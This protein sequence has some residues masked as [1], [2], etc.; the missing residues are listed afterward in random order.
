MRQEIINTPQD[1]GQGDSLFV[2]FN[3]LNQMTLELYNQDSQFESELQAIQS[4]V[5]T[6][7]DGVS[8]L[9]HK[10]TISQ[11]IGLQ[12]ALNSKVS[13]T[14]FNSQIVAINQTIQQINLTINVI[15][16]ELQTKISDAPS[17]GNVYGRKDGDWVEVEADGITGGGTRNFIPKFTPDET[18]IG[19][20]V[21]ANNANN[22]TIGS[23]TTPYR[24][25]VLGVNA[26]AN[27]P[28]LA[29]RDNGRVGIRT[30]TPTAEL[31]IVNTSGGTAPNILTLRNNAT[32][33]GTG[34]ALAFINSTNQ[35]ATVGSKIESVN[36][37][38][39]GRN[40][41]GFYV[42]GGGG[43]FGGLEERM[44]VDG[45]GTLSARTLSATTAFVQGVTTSFSGFS[46]NYNDNKNFGNF[47]VEN[48]TYAKFDFN[49]E[50]TSDDNFGSIIVTANPEEGFYVGKA[51]SISSN[52]LQLYTDN[53][54]FATTNFNTSESNSF[55]FNSIE[56]IT[57]KPIQA[58]GFR[59]NYVYYDTD[60]VADGN[61]PQGA[62]YWNA[63]RQTLQLK[64]NGT[65]Y[66]YG[67]GLYFYIKNQSGVQINKGDV[68]GFAGT[69]G[70]SGII[71][72]AKY[73]NDGSQ[74]SDRLM[75]VA[76]ENIP[77]GGEGKVVFFGEVRGINTNAF[78]EGTILYASNI[79]AGAL[80]STIPNAGTNKGE[81]AAVISQS[82]TVGTIF[83]RALINK[84]IDELNNVD[85]D[86]PTDGQTLVYDNGI[87]K[88]QTVLANL[89]I[90]G[91]NAASIP[92]NVNINGGGA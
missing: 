85:I 47:G 38:A 78:T 51:D 84:N 79:T 54:E 40:K 77:N 66:D 44:W 3:K 45:T 46:F 53:F 30:T 88:N 18:S 19:D 89:N 90:D 13:T 16:D 62:V 24:L 29:V 71:L 82:S 32:G 35:N 37:L 4:I 22:V 57:T 73:V 92:V 39:N 21:M 34:N 36:I 65:D 91:G 67:M 7:N 27:Q 11:I 10:H 9:D 76:K 61:E 55:R 26:T 8:T 60:Y 31:S 41:L 80:S 43:V 12:T 28:L 59:G 64:M 63:D 58:E 86:T 52:Y 25:Y 6:I 75:G 23:I 70:M 69:L 81:I 42:H 49:S 83:V 20:S 87:W 17:D 68:V 2:A 74:P 72:G 14:T 5:N 33:I 1:S 50:D 56:T 48:N 15:L